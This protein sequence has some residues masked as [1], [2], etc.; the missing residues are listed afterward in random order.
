[1]KPPG[2]RDASKQA[3][4]QLPLTIEEMK[5]FS[6]EARLLQEP[7]DWTLSPSSRTYLVASAMTWPLR[8]PGDTGYRTASSDGKRK[9]GS[10]VRTGG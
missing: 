9:C 6:P 4:S 10:K 8:R 2:S 7:R 5:E 3:E 1:L